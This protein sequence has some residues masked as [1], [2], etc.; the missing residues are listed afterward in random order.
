VDLRRRRDD[1]GLTSG[2]GP[3]L[4]RCTPRG[5]GGGG[6]GGLKRGRAHD[7]RGTRIGVHGWGGLENRAG[8]QLLSASPLV[9]AR[10]ARCR[11]SGQPEG[12][13]VAAA[14]GPDAGDDSP[15]RKGTHR[16]SMSGAGG[17]RQGPGCRAWRD[18]DSCGD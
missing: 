6:G 4:Y 15:A 1:R 8:W 14:G 12:G 18:W 9:R 2:T 3:S 17:G 7:K 13:V 10:R 5:Q 11:G 16:Q